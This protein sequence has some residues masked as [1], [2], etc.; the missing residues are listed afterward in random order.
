VA[1]ILTMQENLHFGA[2]VWRFASNRKEAICVYAPCKLGE[3]KYDEGSFLPKDRE[4]CQAWARTYSKPWTTF[5]PGRWSP[6][7]YALY[8]PLT[9]EDFQWLCM[10]TVTRGGCIEIICSKELSKQPASLLTPIWAT[11]RPLHYLCLTNLC[12]ELDVSWAYLL[13]IYNYA[14]C[15]SVFLTES[16]AMVDELLQQA[17]DIQDCIVV[18]TEQALATEQKNWEDIYR[19]FE[20]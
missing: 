19:Q 18:P 12:R 16:P 1:L 7:D 11:A 5:I 8:R 20:E 4:K 9:E 3:K 2:P 14:P 10:A 15:F 17:K 13:A 6:Q